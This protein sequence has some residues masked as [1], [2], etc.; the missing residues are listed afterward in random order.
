MSVFGRGLS[1]TRRSFFGRIATLLSG[2]DI[3]EDTW[4]DIEALLI[5]ADLGLAVTQKGTGQP[6]AQTTG[7]T[8]D[9]AT[10]RFARDPCRDALHA[11]A[12]GP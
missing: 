8:A 1:R 12:P 5:Q 4:D 10:G 7:A 9:R 6:C 2:N 3:D 11:T